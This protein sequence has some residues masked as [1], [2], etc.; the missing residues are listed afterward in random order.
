MPRSYTYR[1]RGTI[2]LKNTGSAGITV[3]VGIRIDENDA[4]GRI[5]RA[6]INP[7]QVTLNPG[8]S[9]VVEISGTVRLRASLR[10]VGT[11]VIA[12][13]PTLRNV[14]VTVPVTFV[15]R[16]PWKDRI[17]ITGVSQ[18][19][20]TLVVGVRNTSA[21]TRDVIVGATLTTRITGSGCQLSIPPGADYKDLPFRRVTI[22]GGGSAN[23]T[24]NLSHSDL[25]RFRYVIV[26]VWDD[27]PTKYDRRIAY[28]LCLDGTAKEL[29]KVQYGAQILSAY[30]SGGRLYVTVKNTGN[31][32]KY[33]WIGATVIEE[34]RYAGSGCNLY[35]TGGRTWD[36]P[37]K[38]IGLAPGQSGT[39]TYDL[40]SLP[41]GRYQVIVKVWHDYDR[42]LNVMK[43]PCYDG[44]VTNAFEVGARVTATGGSITAVPY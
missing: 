26:K 44:R 24:W 10:H 1:V 40:P 13:D 27:D 4:L 15:P 42:Y 38:S 33:Y 30:V 19:D 28:K 21:V 34:G 3:Y 20:S 2:T 23:V 16:N 22:Y 17:K 11:F 9:K 37:P 39:V 36:L 31:V 35:V 6:T 12:S 43:P 29:T 5:Y 32:G 25:E 41:A 18:T 14:L 8:E 7:V